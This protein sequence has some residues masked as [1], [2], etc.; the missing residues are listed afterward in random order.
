M[1]AIFT[2]TGSQASISC[3]TSLAASNSELSVLIGGATLS[4]VLFPLT[5]LSIAQSYASGIP[6]LTGSEN[7]TSATGAIMPLVGVTV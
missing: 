5:A 2:N 4:E 3:V 1:A 6:T 7:W